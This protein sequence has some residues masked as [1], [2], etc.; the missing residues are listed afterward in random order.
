MDD[1]IFHTVLDLFIDIIIPLFNNKLYILNKK[2]ILPITG[3]INIM[4]FIRS[5]PQR[6]MI[7][8]YYGEDVYEEY[9]WN[10]YIKYIKEE[11]TEYFEYNTQP[12]ILK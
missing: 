9:G 1:I 7:N 10:E 6:D 8:H 2:F 5:Q 3:D 12:S 11:L 4:D